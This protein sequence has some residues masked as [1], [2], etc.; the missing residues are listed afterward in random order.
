MFTSLE[1]MEKSPVAKAALGDY[2]YEEFISSKKKEWNTYRKQVT[3]W[4]LK[5]YLDV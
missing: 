5:K 3:P 4:E 2:I 1:E